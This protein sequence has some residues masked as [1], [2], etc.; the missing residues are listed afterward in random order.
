MNTATSIKYRH[1][2]QKKKTTKKWV[3]AINLLGELVAFINL[4]IFINIFGIFY[5]NKLLK[6]KHMW[7]KIAVFWYKR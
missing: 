1:S 7:I 3:K 5:M 4:H 6:F 2:W